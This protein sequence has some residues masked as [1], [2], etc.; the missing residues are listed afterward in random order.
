LKRQ[1]LLQDCQGFQEVQDL[2]WDKNRV[3]ISI[4]ISAVE[5]EIRQQTIIITCLRHGNLAEITGMW[6]HRN[7]G[8]S[9]K[10]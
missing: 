4:L 3:V 9:E 8:S 7:L 10:W 2:R 1:I 6:F 5:M